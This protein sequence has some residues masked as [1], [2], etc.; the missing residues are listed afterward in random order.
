[1]DLLMT[2]IVLGVSTGLVYALAGVGLVVIYRTSGY[3]SFA[4]GDIAAVALYTGLALH[5]AGWRYAWVALSV[6]V[7]GAILGGIIG[8]GIVVPLERYGPISAALATVAV[9]LIIQGLELIFVGGEPR[10]FPSIGEQT[11]ATVGGVGVTASD[12]FAIVVAGLL[13]S[14]MGL[15][16]RYT[17]TGMA[18]RAANDNPQAA[19]HVGIAQRRL[20]VLSW[21]V[22]GGLA[23]VCGLFIAPAF[24]LTPTSVNAII[25]FGFLTVVVG[26]FESVLGTVIAGIT[27]GVVGNLVAAYV[28]SQLVTTGVYVLLVAVLIFRPYGL[29]GRRPLVRV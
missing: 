28:D 3:V 22:A 14:A 26:G 20:K 10:A 5:T 16:F 8:A 2:S 4:Q 19:E 11:V 1:M 23:G 9:G 17:K 27:L 6:V 12:V 29:F 24:T 25:V 15:A 21:V 7:V 13:F 18:V